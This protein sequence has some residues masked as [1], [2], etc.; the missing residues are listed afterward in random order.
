M[1]FQHLL[2]IGIRWRLEVFATAD[3][4]RSPRPSAPETHP[5]PTSGP[6]IG[7]GQLSHGVA[8]FLTHP[9]RGIRDLLG[10]SWALAWPWVTVAVVLTASF[11]V[12]VRIRRRRG[13]REHRANARWVQVVPPLAVDP[14]AGQVLWHQL[15]GMLSPG[16]SASR[17]RALSWELHAT[18]ERVQAA[19]WA[20]GNLPAGDVAMTLRGAF[21]RAATRVGSLLVR[22]DQAPNQGV[23]ASPPH[24]ILD[25]A[26][27]TRERVAAGYLVVPR[28]DMWQPLLAPTGQGTARTSS[29]VSSRQA[30]DG[31]AMI[32][33]ALA[34]T[35]R[36]YASIVQ[37]LARP[38]RHGTRT[39][40]AHMRHVDPGSGRVRSSGPVQRA[41]D[42]SVRVPAFVLRE[43]LDV[44]TPGS[45]P[46]H[47]SSPTARPAPDPVVQARQRAAAAKAAC[48]FVEVCV[49][50]VVTG[51]SRRV[52][53]EHAWLVANAHRAALTGQAL[54]AV[55]VADLDVRVRDHA[56]GNG[57]RLWL[58]GN[59]AGHRGG[60]FVATASELGALARLPVQPSLHGFDIAGAPHLPAPA[61]VPR[62]HTGRPRPTSAVSG[63]DDQDDGLSTDGWEA[64]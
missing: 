54:G 23:A 28:Q 20:P 12:G 29:G 7:T 11:A 59:R 48:E 62:L 63:S 1:V 22:P 64:A 18:C 6:R 38:P 49:R 14:G 32:A 36:G 50:V 60:W 56:L 24:R 8:G 30:Q 3:P 37:V 52:C 34:A 25:R 31:L 47:T 57:A 4:R 46:S 17:V 19:M 15:I 21:P 26:P 40:G 2:P 51:A 53:R 41:L 10:H 27:R 13:W 9:G 44:L 61:Q 55:G 16:G 45:H 58:G 35:P 43:V 39:A 42:L 33:M 5:V